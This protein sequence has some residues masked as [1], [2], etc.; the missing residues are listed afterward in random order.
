MV[1]KSYYLMKKLLFI[2]LSC[3]LYIV[4]SFGQ[5]EGG[6]NIY[7]AVIDTTKMINNLEVIK[8]QLL[9]DKYFLFNFSGGKSSLKNKKVNEY[10]DKGA[11]SSFS[12]DLNFHK[13]FMNSETEDDIEI[14]KPSLF[15]FNV[16]IG[17]SRY[18]N[19]RSFKNEAFTLKN[20]TD[21]DGDLADVY[22]QYHNIE[23]SV[24]T[25]YFNI[26]VSLEI[27][28]SS[29]TNLSVWAA[30]GLRASFLINKDFV[31]K[32]TYSS[33]GYYEKWG[34]SLHDIPELAYYTQKNAYEDVRYQFSPFVIWGTLSAGISI[35]L[36]RP[37][38]NKVNDFIIRAG[39]KCDRSLFSISKKVDSQLLFN[40]TPYRIGESNLLTAGKAYLSSINFELGLIY[41]LW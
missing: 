37:E 36:S 16:G 17:I 28:K 13:Q 26:P 19:L 8:K 32:G 41:S 12:F 31:G 18:G 5:I 40:D 38:L 24:K 2:I 6:N 27:G 29:V 1:L 33:E 23:E 34:T 21:A 15:G 4:P 10:W 11:G 30:L 22:F 7:S 25:T 9:P 39:L 35:P 14:Y 20:H 3:F